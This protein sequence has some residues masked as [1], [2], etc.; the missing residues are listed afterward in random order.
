[1]SL[2]SPDLILFEEAFLDKL[3]YHLSATREYA[4][5]F[6]SFTATSRC[7]NCGNQPL[8]LHRWEPINAPEFGYFDYPNKGTIRCD[9]CEC[10][11]AF[12]F[13]ETEILRDCMTLDIC[14]EWSG[15]SRKVIYRRIEKSEWEIH[16]FLRKQNRDCTTEEIAEAVSTTILESAEPREIEPGAWK[17]ESGFL[18][19]RHTVY[20]NTPDECW[21]KMKHKRMDVT[22]R[23]L[24]SMEI[25]HLIT[26]TG[27]HKWKSAL[28]PKISPT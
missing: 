11:C 25:R 6:A 21:E 4:S 9:N 14:L 28:N 22:F 23:L 7:P 19:D 16:Q 27:P 24:Y 2:T 3:V 13:I 1:M 12:T 8:S 5:S 18:C 17:F 26:K 10:E 15:L 20:G